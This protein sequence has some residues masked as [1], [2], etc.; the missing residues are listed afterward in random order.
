[1]VTWLVAECRPPAP[2]MTVSE[3][4]YATAPTT[5]GPPGAF[6][7]G[8]L[9]EPCRAL[10]CAHQT[11]LAKTGSTNGCLGFTRFCANCDDLLVVDCAVTDNDSQLFA[12]SRLE[13]GSYMMQVKHTREY[14][15]C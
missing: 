15:H 12:M 1:M 6:L 11:Q 3:A 13:D 8:L 4:H 9:T 2:C 14:W 5:P 7:H 10:P